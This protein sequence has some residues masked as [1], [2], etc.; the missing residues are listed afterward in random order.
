MQS[1][2][3]VKAL[4]ALSLAA[5]A[6]VG[7]GVKSAS[8]ATLSLFY[9]AGGTGA[10]GTVDAVKIGTSSALTGAAAGTNVTVNP[11]AA[12]VTINIPVGD[13]VEFG[14][15]ALVSNNVN[16]IAGSTLKTSGGLA[17][18]GV[19][20]PTYLGL[21]GLAVQIS[22]S[23][24]TG[25]TLAPLH[26]AAARDTFSG[27]VDYNSTSKLNATLSTAAVTD[28]GDVTAQ[29]SVG[30]GSVGFHYLIAPLGNT[31]ENANSPAGVAALGQFTT[32]TNSTAAA[33]ATTGFNNVLFQGDATGTVSLTPF[34]NSSATQY[35]AYSGLP[36]TTGPNV[37][38]LYG[39]TDFTNPGDVLGTLP[40]LVINI[41]GTTSVSTSH[42]IISLT[43]SAP[44]SYGSSQG[45]A[46]LSGHNGSYSVAT[47]GPF[48]GTATG[49][50][51]ATLFN[52]AT[53]E[54]IYAIDVA[55]ESNLAALVSAI[56]NG[57]S[58]VSKSLLVTA[59]TSY[60]G[61]P[62][63]SGPSPFGSQYNLFLDSPVGPG[64]GSPFL[65][66]DF[67]STNDSNLSGV[68]FS[69][70]AVVPEPM[71][72]GLLALGGL[73]LMTRRHRKI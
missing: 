17:A 16:G 11:S 39:A 65:G 49:F 29:G 53:D 14:V 70:V 32:Q 59:A 43:T 27:V 13:Y 37:T 18:G 34:A 31:G 58:A 33:S 42:P 55:G 21:S 28:V 69:E 48:A 4:S 73:G 56:N 26:A 68:T 71:T 61:L 45:T 50:I 62:G 52:P 66:I 20:Q 54:E 22:S 51:E 67:S 23:D 1:A 63:V 36:P 38:K 46:T 72:L 19:A 10:A 8:A 24:V 15:S 12:A 60:D 44:T 25:S 64:S 9:N 3:K 5:A 35:W 30:G 7:F 47:V 6:V 40:L 2:K 57:D 41:T